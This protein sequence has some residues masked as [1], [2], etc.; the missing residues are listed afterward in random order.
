MW[1]RLRRFTAR[2]PDAKSAF[3]WAGCLL[4]A[5]AVSLRLRGFAATRRWLLGTL[6]PSSGRATRSL[7]VQTVTDTE[8]RMVRAAG[9]YLPFKT[10][11]LERSLVL[12]WLLAH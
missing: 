7:D 9:R 11:C 8:T 6:S 10:T 1:E 4:P 2:P 5:I 3:L 12:F